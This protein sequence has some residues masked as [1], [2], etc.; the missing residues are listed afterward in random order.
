M[1]YI[2]NNKL[3]DTYKQSWKTVYFKT[4]LEAIENLEFKDEII[5]VKWEITNNTIE[6]II[7]EINVA[8]P[9]YW[10]NILFPE[11]SQSIHNWVSKC[12]KSLCKGVLVP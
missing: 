2:Y 12:H 10:N 3:Q 5:L 9:V 7:D 1:Y 6:A 11:L 4:R 8:M